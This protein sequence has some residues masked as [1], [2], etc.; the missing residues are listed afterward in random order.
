MHI[1]QFYEE[2]HALGRV[3]VVAYG[4]H[5][6]AEGR[7][8]LSDPHLGKKYVAYH[9]GIELHI[10]RDPDTQIVFGEGEGLY[11]KKYEYWIKL[12]DA[13]GNDIIRISL[14]KPEGSDDYDAEGLAAYHKLK[15]LCEG[16]AN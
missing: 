16:T 10:T 7:T 5:V 14:L 1:D 11:S 4:N 3:Y 8:V 2:L 9:G 6:F 12:R 13:D 15:G